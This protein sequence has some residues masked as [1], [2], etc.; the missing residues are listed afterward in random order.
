MIKVY[1]PVANHD[2]FKEWFGSITEYQ[3]CSNI[4]EVLAEP[5]KIA[6]VPVYFDEIGYDFDYTQ[7]DLLLI[8]DIEFNHIRPVKQWL[9]RLRIKNYLVVLGGLEGYSLSGDFVYRPWWTFN[10]MSRNQDLNKDIDT[11]PYVFDMLLGARKPHRDWILAKSIETGLESHSICMY[12]DVFPAPEYYDED[13]KVTVPYPFVSTN[14]KQEYEVSDNINFQVSDRVPWGIYEQT[15]YSVVPETQYRNTFFFSEKPA[16]VIFAKRLFVVFS[17]HNYLK[18]M[19][20]EL[21]FKTFDCVID[22]S[23]DTE[24]N[25]V[26]RFEMAFEQML[27]LADMDYKEVQFRTEE[28]REFNYHRLYELRQEKYQQMQNMVYN[29]LK[30]IKNAN[31]V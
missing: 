14:M 22:E 20:E 16:K 31:S 17:C 4:N 7:F 29:K 25:T 13:I 15:R 27:K 18:Q 19:R 21:G 11:K 12:R 8:S 3:K 28:I 24:E 2:I 9:E 26:K 5:I 30:E 1:T 10:L 23:Y 6:C